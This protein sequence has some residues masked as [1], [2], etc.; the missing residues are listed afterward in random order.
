MSSPIVC[1]H[2]LGSYLGCDFCKAGT[3]QCEVCGDFDAVTENERKE[4]VCFACAR[5]PKKKAVA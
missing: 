2:C 1:S 5:D 3:V 4:R